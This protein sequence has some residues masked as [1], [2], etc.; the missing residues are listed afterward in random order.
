MSLLTRHVALIS[1]SKR[2]RTGD[3]MRVAAALQK[4][5]IRDLTPIWGLSATVDAFDKLEDVPLGYWPIIVM[6]NIDEP[7]AA[8][9][10]KDENGQP[11]ALVS[12]ADALDGWSLTASHEALEMLVDPFGN[13]LVAGESPAQGQ[14]RVEFLVEVCDPS[15]A[16][17]YGY[18]VNGILVSDFYTPR[19]FDPAK[20]A[21]VRYS[22]RGVISR[23]REVLPGGYLSWHDPVSDH[24]F[25]LIA[26]DGQPRIRDIGKLDA[27][28]DSLR[29]QID[30]ITEEERGRV[31]GPRAAMRAGSAARTS[32]A[33]TV[34]Q[35]SRVEAGRLR[36]QIEELR[37]SRAG[38]QTE[39]IRA[40]EAADGPEDVLDCGP[41]Y[42]VSAG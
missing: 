14:G 27:R 28:A 9:V 38:R 15:E 1:E 33:E 31:N 4:Q 17:N 19:Y 11:F 30:R 40:S 32:S 25:Q 22:F 29:A 37:G 23:P 35:S 20:A 6:D 13:R 42:P 2:I 41:K 26:F 34:E 16:A 3:V 8:G 21:G 36:A 12:A 5:A 24:W 39:Q 10:H 18:R 7:G